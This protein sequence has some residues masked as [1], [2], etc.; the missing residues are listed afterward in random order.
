MS[1]EITIKGDGVAAPLRLWPRERFTDV[2]MTFNGTPGT[3]Y[4]IKESTNGVV[5]FEIKILIP[6]TGTWSAP[7][8]GN[9][10]PMS[11]KATL[12]YSKQIDRIGDSTDDTLT[13]TVS[14]SVTFTFSTDGFTI[15]KN[16]SCSHC[17]GVCFFK[18]YTK[19]QLT[20][21]AYLNNISID[22]H[23]D[24]ATIVKNIHEGEINM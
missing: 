17:K 15:T 14:D 13:N 7:V 22:P 23:A 2:Q 19:K 3:T 12:E 8:F 11:G 18:D 9:S 16:S 10:I 6:E 20:K 5:D 24:E 21:Y 4:L 1:M